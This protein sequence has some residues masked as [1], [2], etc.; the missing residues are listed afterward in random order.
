M[1]TQASS[2]KMSM[3]GWGSFRVSLVNFLGRPSFL[4]CIV[5]VGLVFWMRRILRV[6]S[7]GLV[8]LSVF[9]HFCQ[10]LLRCHFAL[11]FVTPNTQAISTVAIKC[12]AHG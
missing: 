2:W 7:V 12:I 5:A 3:R 6:L 4:G 10:R 9:V 8:L 11:V 1:V